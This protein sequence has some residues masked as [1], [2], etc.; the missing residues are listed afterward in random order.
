MYVCNHMNVA[1]ILKTH[2]S[3]LNKIKD[4]SSSIGA[5]IAKTTFFTFV[6]KEKNGVTINYKNIYKNKIERDK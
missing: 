3:L 2:I 5:K 4:E 1:E 6:L